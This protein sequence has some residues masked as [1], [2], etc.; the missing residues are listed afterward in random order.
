MRRIFLIALA[1]VLI[2][3]VVIPVAGY[4]WL[5]TSL[6]LTNGTVRVDRA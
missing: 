4:L 5:R 6:P 3:L 2:L 1:I